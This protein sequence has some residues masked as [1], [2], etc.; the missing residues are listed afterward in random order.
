MI[1]ELGL[2]EQE[3]MTNKRFIKAEYESCEVI[4]LIESESRLLKAFPYY[5]WG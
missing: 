5:S 4:L 2:I 1:L 3:V